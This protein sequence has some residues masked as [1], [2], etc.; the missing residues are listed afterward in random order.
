M[1]AYFESIHIDLWDVVENGNYIPY[2][3][4]LNE[5]PRSLWMEEQKLIFLL[6]SK[7]LN[8][9]MC[10]LL[11]EKYTK[12]HSFR[13]AKKMWDTLV[14]T[15]E[16]MSQIKKNKISLL[17][18]KYELIS[19]EE[20]EDIQNMFGGFQT[21]LIELQFLGIT[22]DNYDHIYKILRKLIETLKVHEQELQHDRGLKKNKS[23]ALNVQKTKK[24]SLSKE[25]S[26]KSAF[27]GSSQ[28]LRVEICFNE[29]SKDKSD[30]DEFAFIS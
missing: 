24:A 7:A 16:G 13:S 21:I 2:D 3:D 23:L 22:Y 20:R 28:A 14:I 9:M 17:T 8:V 25:T 15:Y 1:I 18:R 30:E 12:V 29:E 19:I 4:E 26:S 27:K 6:N 10:T 11:E 5:I